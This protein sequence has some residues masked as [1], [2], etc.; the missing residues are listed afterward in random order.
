MNTPAATRLHF[1]D[2]LRGWGSLAV[3]LFHV[4]VLGFPIDA[5]TTA[6]LR[7]LALFNGE[8]AV[9]VFFIVS[10]FSLA[11]Q[12]C[13]TRSPAVL[14][15]IA[16]GRYLRLAIPILLTCLIV[17]LFFVLGVI[18]APALR[19][20]NFA[21]HLLEA[22]SLLETLRFALFDVFFHYSSAKTLVPPLWTMRFEL[23]GSCLVLV[24][25]YVVGDLRRRFFIYAALALI[26]CLFSVHYLAFMIGLLLAELFTAQDMQPL[27]DGLSR[28]AWMLFIAGLACAA[29]LPANDA[30]HP[31]PY[32]GVACLLTVPVMFNQRLAG[33][34][35]GPLSRFLGRISFPLYLIHAPLFFAYGLNAQRLAGTLSSVGAWGLGLSIA[36]LCVL[37][38]VILIPMDTLGMTIARRFSGWVM[39]QGQLRGRRGA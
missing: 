20:A 35:S 2:G 23:L 9:R 32:L 10:G 39:A 3:L 31:W 16:L 26:T 17:K 28:A 30:Q 34:L 14:Q 38:A 19:S 4:F 7:P 21:K 24:T 12:Y 36:L 8:L 33:L 22:P 25:L 18:P 1:L 37:T 13:Q 11:V 15:R 29:L 6:T 27:R 5:Q